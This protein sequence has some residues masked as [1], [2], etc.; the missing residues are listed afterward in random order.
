M[1]QPPDIT[2][3]SANRS[4]NNTALPISSHSL[5]YNRARSP[6]EPTV[7]TLEHN[8]VAMDESVASG[9][10]VVFPIPIRWPQFR[11]KSGSALCCACMNDRLTAGMGVALPPRCNLRGRHTDTRR[12]QVPNHNGSNKPSCPGHELHLLARYTTLIDVTQQACGANARLPQFVRKL[13]PVLGVIY[14]TPST[15]ECEPINSKYSAFFNSLILIRHCT[16]VS[17]YCLIN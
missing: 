6:N 2:T 14:L 1:K 10:L 15:L 13:F 5:P 17:H 12:S 7:V 9:M 11:S 16:Y 4:A 3:R 8:T